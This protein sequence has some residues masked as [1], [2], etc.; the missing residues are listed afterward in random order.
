MTLYTSDVFEIV[1]MLVLLL[2]GGGAVVVF[3]GAIVVVMA[4]V[5]FKLELVNGIM[6][7]SMVG[8]ALNFAGV[9]GTGAGAGVVVVVIVVV[10][11]MFVPFKFSPLTDKTEDF[12]EFFKRDIS[13]LTPASIIPEMLNTNTNFQY[14]EHIF[15][16]YLFQINTKCCEIF[17]YDH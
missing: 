1:C 11:V 10:S 13:I 5:E 8:F 2:N 12:C 17:C 4:F 15:S 14:S 6:L 9:V 7:D 3:C 16:L